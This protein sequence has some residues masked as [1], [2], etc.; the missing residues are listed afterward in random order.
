MC[1]LTLILFMIPSLIEDRFKIELLNTLQA[2]ILLFIFV[3]D[4]LGEMHNFYGMVPYWDTMLHTI[5]GFLAAA[6]RFSRI[7]ILNRSDRFHFKMLPLFVALLA[8]CFSMTI[9]VLWEFFEFG[10]DHLLNKDMKKYRT[11][12]AGW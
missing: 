4:I 8:F 6:I 11:D 7:D 1:T 5:N 9:G 12:R 3:A 2:I 10:A